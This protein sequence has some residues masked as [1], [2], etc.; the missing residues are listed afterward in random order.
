MKKEEATRFLKAFRNDKARRLVH[1]MMTRH[2]TEAI[3]EHH[4]EP[5]SLDPQKIEQQT[6][7]LCDEIFKKVNR[8]GDE[9]EAVYPLVTSLSRSHR[10]RSGIWFAAF[11]E[12]YEN[13]KHHRKLGIKLEQLVPFLG[14]GTYADI[15]CGGGDLVSYLKAHYGKFSSYTGI[16]VMDWRSEEVREKIDFM[17][18]N[19]AHPE[20]ILPVQFDFATCMAVLHHVGSDQASRLHFLRNI[21]ASLRPEGRLLVE[22][23]VILPAGEIAADLHLQQQTKQ[24]MREQPLYGAYLEMESHEQEDVLILIDLLANSLTVGVPDMDLPFGFRTINEWTVLFRKAGFVP[25][26]I[27]ITG[28]VNRTF[29]RSSHVIYLLRRN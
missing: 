29:N 22:E 1:V 7:R 27:R 10:P 25:E 19:F 3:L 26:K 18:F 12:A 15:G 8:I 2:Y 23:D 11:N 17:V 20:G 16:D 5:A 9:P 6:R 4:P 24:L 13:Y 21:R 28:F 14:T